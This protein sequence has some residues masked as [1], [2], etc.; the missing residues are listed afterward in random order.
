MT[1]PQ[2]DRLAAAQAELLRALL[3]GG[4]PPAGFDRDRL[5]I[6]ARA[7]LNK[8]R[9]IVAAL[10]PDLVEA[11]G[12]RFRPLFDDYARAHPRR[13]GTRMRQ[14]AAAFAEWAAARGELEPPRKRR[15]WQRR[16]T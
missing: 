10:R 4:E 8:R 11:L 14:D 7:L 3:A 9:G 15:W 1:G 2:R 16:A 6:E 12:E 5:R 13:E